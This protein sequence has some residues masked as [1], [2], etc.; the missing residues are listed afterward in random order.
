MGVGEGLVHSGGDWRDGSG[1]RRQGNGKDENDR[2]YDRDERGGHPA[3]TL[4]SVISYQYGN[5]GG[6]GPVLRPDPSKKT[7]NP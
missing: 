1:E 7:T 3:I 6:K 2:A 4:P 5:C